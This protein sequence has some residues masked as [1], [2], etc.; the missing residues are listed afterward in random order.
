MFGWRERG[1]GA[2]LALEAGVVG[3]RRE[4]LQRDAPPELVICC[5]PDLGHPAA[6]EAL[7][8]A[9]TA[10]QS[11]RPAASDTLC[12]GSCGLYSPSGGAGADLGARRASL[13]AET[14]RSRS[15]GGTCDRGACARRRRPAA[16]PE[17]GDGRIRACG[18]AT[19][20]GRLPV[21]GGHRRRAGRPCVRSLP[22][23]AM[24]ISTG[25]VVPDGADAVV[26]DRGML[27]EV[28]TQ[29]SGRAVAAG[30]HVRP[31]GGDVACGRRG[32]RTG[33]PDWRGA[34]RRT[35]RRRPRGGLVRATP[36][37]RGAR[38][39]QRARA[40]RRAA[41]PGEVYEANS[42]MLAAALAA[43][44]RRGRAAPGRWQTTRRPIA[45]RSSAGSP[46]TCSSRPAASPSARTISCAASRPSSASRRSSGGSRSSRASRS[47][48]ACAGR[49]SCSGCPAI[50]S[51]RSSAASCSSSPRS[52]ALRGCADPLPRFEPGRLAR[53]CRAT[54]RRDELVRA[55]AHVDAAG[56]V[57]EPLSGQESH[58]IVRAAAAERARPRPSRR[59]RARR[60]GAVRGSAQCRVTAVPAAADVI[61]RAATRST[62]RASRRRCSGASRRS[63]DGTPAA[64][65]ARGAVTAAPRDRRRRTMRWRV[66]R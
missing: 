64:R 56:V 46:P 22:G 21:V 40:T 3:V 23:E 28:T 62:R 25:G 16:V 42:L 37:R 24:E 39:R 11:C 45:P 57:L 14:V 29:S 31:R 33:R 4:Q 20:P 15:G 51:R 27:S 52:R 50:R 41:R 61:R 36:T 12:A 10:R 63:A 53:R 55:R 48:S 17:L 30:E 35:G 60:R 7:V 5:G 18:R 13:A 66:T 38:D 8:E 43:V 59:R 19:Y 58:M 47:R 32:R 65:A 1:D 2:G 44:G 49:R 9:V 6:A 26:P 34:A 54:T